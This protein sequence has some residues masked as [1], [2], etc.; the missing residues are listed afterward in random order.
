MRDRDFEQLG[1]EA[2]EEKY[3][4]EVFWKCCW[5]IVILILLLYYLCGKS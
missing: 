1:D 3:Y 4:P 2:N 5:V